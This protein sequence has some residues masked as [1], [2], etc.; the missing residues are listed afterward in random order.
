[1]K[2]SNIVIIGTGRFAC[3]T[4]E[5]CLVKTKNI[6]CIEPENPSFPTL[7]SMCIKR[8]VK[9]HCLLERDK[10]TTF[11]RGISSPTLVI[12][13]YNSFMFPK[14][15]LTSRSLLIINF[16]NSLLPRHRGRN[17]PT[18]TIFEMDAVTG[19]TWHLVSAE[20]D[21]G[22]IICQRM[23]AVPADINALDLTRKTLDLGAAAFQE[24]LPSLLDGTYGSES[25]GDPI[26]ETFHLSTDVP[27]G[28]ILD[29][30]WSLPKAHAFL[31]SLDYGNLKVFPPAQIQFLG[32]H[33]SVLKYAAK[34]DERGASQGASAE[35]HDGQLVLRDGAMCLTI[36]CLK[37]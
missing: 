15:V 7:R 22:D 26:G 18:F 2:P 29:L 30:G 19:I 4:L 12:S 33:F 37:N 5:A 3:A 27:N 23:M 34:H 13:A 1:M 31:R 11:F 10:L 24:I 25:G 9:Y 35:T 36:D 28:G 20:I 14:A 16:H 6:E 17:A 8:S 32:E 21:K